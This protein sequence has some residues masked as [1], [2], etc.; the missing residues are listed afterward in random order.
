VKS[1]KA[2]LIITNHYPGKMSGGS[3][4][5]LAFINSMG[6]L[7]E[8]CFLIYP[9]NGKENCGFFLK[10]IR[11]IPCEDNR[12]PWLKG[13]QVYSGKL[14]RFAAMAIGEMMK[15]NPHIVAFDTSIVSRGILKEVIRHNCKIVTLHHNIEREFIRD[16]PPSFLYSMPYRYYLA[17]AEKT[18]LTHST[19]N[20]TLTEKDREEFVGYYGGENISQIRCLGVSEPEGNMI[21]RPQK[22]NAQPYK[23]A[24]KIVI[25]GSL[26]FRQ[27]EMSIKDFINEYW[28]L[29]RQVD[30]GSELII[31]G[32]YPTSQLAAICRK[33]QG[34]RLIANPQDM[35]E[36]VS[37]CDI[38]VCPVNSG[39]GFKYRIMDGLR[40]G[41][42]V[43]VHRK[44][45]YGYEKII[46]KGCVFIY[47]SKETF[48]EAITKL[49]SLKFEREDILKSYLDTFSFDKGVS[50]LRSILDDAG[51]L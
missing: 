9:S 14:H 44:S 28:P 31:A 37:G 45:S 22:I 38:Y 6:S 51:L 41:L 30:T 12:Q 27:S 7:F 29:T 5:S 2:V 46:E 11:L 36:I 49:N 8:N 20:L 34:I 42:P 40:A 48:T 35:S 13:F 17:G 16:N 19:M 24:K 21:H 47:D 4:A 1:E 26:K 43:L 3:I 50:R 23:K 32:S 25:T 39:S 10:N 18:A 33:N 15:I